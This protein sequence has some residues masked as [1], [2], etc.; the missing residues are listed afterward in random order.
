MALA[1]F[2][3]PTDLVVTL[4][5]ALD[6]I[7]QARAEILLARASDRIRSYTGQQLTYV[8]NDTQILRVDG[9][10]VVLPQ[11]PNQKP[12]QIAYA[13]GSG[14]IAASAWWWGG[15]GVVDLSPPS[16]VANGPSWGSLRRVNTVAVT[17]THG[18]EEIPG[19]I[20]DITVE[21]VSRVFA[22]PGLMPGLREG[23][24]DDF[25]FALG[26]NLVTGQVALTDMNEADLDKYRRR[27]G[28]RKL[29]A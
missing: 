4:G 17:Y 25:R 21:M 9:G 7:E 8:E 12:S 15:V 26:G 3:T 28:S 1:P 27:T 29:L 13:D 23:Q 22:V 14:V 2:A 6:Q 24:I 5:R 16:W 11:W 20:I 19:D 18:Y 10:Q